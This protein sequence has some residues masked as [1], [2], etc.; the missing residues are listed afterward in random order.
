MYCTC[1][2]SRWSQLFVGLTLLGDL[3][4]FHTFLFGFHEL[5]IFLV[6]YFFSILSTLFSA[7][8]RSYPSESALFIGRHWKQNFSPN[9]NH[10]TKYFREK[11]FRTVFKEIYILN[12]IMKIKRQMTLLFKNIESVI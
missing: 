12:D 5:R 1:T 7:A 11:V 2:G 3:N 8:N 6:L 4:S 9:G 10:P